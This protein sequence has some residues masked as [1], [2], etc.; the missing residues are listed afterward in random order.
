MLLAALVLP[1]TALASTEFTARYTVRLA[2]LPFT[3][4]TGTVKAT[5]PDS[6]RYTVDF[7]AKGMG[8]SMNGKASGVVQANVLWPAT[9]VTT[10]SDSNV[11]RTISI[12]LQ[13]GRVRQEAVHPPLPYRPDRVPVQPEHKRGVTD[14]ISAVLMPQLSK[15]GP[16]EPGNCDRTLP[17]F[18]GTERFDIRMSYLRTEIV[19]TLK[20]YE[21][22]AVV[23]RASYKAIAGHREQGSAKSME[24]NRTIEAWLAPIEGTQMMAPWRVS[25]ATGFGMLVLEASEFTSSAAETEKSSIM[26]VQPVSESGTAR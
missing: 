13:R 8:F 11:S 24:K 9:S 1:G 25:F 12:A 16:G 22:P 26:S 7:D 21:G 17:V 15:G 18:E 5:L 3:F 10:A 14:P 6:G 4:A 19:K 23:C 20:G 2:V